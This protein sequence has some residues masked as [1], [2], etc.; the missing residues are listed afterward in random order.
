M[1]GETE[2]LRLHASEIVDGGFALRRVRFSGLTATWPADPGAAP[3]AA[4][5]TVIIDG[6][7]LLDGTEADAEHVHVRSLRTEVAIDAPATVEVLQLR[8]TWSAL[9]WWAPIDAILLPAQP[10]M[11][12]VLVT[13]ATSLL[14]SSLGA[15]SAGFGYLRGSAEALAAAVLQKHAVVPVYPGSSASMRELFDRTVALID[16]RAADPLLTIDAIAAEVNV[17]KQYLQ[18][19][20]RPTGV[21]PLRYLRI[22]RALRARALM[23]DEGADGLRG[24]AE[25]AR[26]V[27]FSSVKAMREVLARELG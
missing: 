22:V 19:A 25:I 9:R 16:A 5:L 13:M 12:Q 23:E 6:R 11:K 7:F 2:G 18:R 3:D 21:S 10:E 27:G 14:H 20:F 4:E 8:T 24:Q 26:T 15:D 1:A 17:S